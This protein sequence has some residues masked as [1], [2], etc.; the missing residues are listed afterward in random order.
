MRYRFLVAFGM[1][2]YA[3]LASGQ[4]FESVQGI[5]NG[6]CSRA[7]RTINAQLVLAYATGAARPTGQLNGKK[8]TGLYVTKQQI[9]FTEGTKDFQGTFSS[10]FN[11]LEAELDK[12]PKTAKCSMSRTFKESDNLCLLNNT[13]KDQF[14]WLDSP[15]GQGGGGTFILRAGQRL[16]ITGDKTGQLCSS[17][18][19]FKPPTCPTK[20]AQR[21]Y[22]CQ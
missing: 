21:H 15:N 14:I 10:D 5:W 11:Q 20:I 16:E 7:G 8:L 1:A 12:G 17:N 13:G 4:S 2:W 3:S 19:D 18:K 6:S 9:S 22:S